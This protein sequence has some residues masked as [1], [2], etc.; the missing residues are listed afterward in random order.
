MW[1]VAMSDQGKK[2]LQGAVFEMGVSKNRG[3]P[4]SSISIGCSIINHPLW[5]TPIFGNTQMAQGSFSRLFEMS[6]GS[7]GISK[8]KGWPR[9]G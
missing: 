2:V 4:K 1:P 3:T 5:G 9:K 6:P 7:Q 8:E